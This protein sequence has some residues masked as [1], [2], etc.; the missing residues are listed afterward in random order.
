MPLVRWARLVYK[1]Y[2]VIMV[3]GQVLV[4]F[5]FPFLKEKV[6]EIFNG[7]LVNIFHG[8]FYG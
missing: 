7:V 1:L 2:Q 5:K 8:I 4:V 3:V 6:C